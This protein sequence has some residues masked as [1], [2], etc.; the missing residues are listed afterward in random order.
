MKSLNQSKQS[1]ALR[2]PKPAFAT[3]GIVV[4]LLLGWIA[5]FGIEILYRQKMIIMILSGIA[6][7]LVGTAFEATRY[8]WRMHRYRVAKKARTIYESFIERTRH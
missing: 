4:G 3:T 5:G 7:A 1:R 2:P 6:G 8:Q